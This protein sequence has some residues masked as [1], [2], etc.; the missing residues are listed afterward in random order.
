MTVTQGVMNRGMYAYWDNL[1]LLVLQLIQIRSE[2]SSLRVRDREY[3]AL[4][5]NQPISPDSYL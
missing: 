3:R 5:I 4:Y 1:N 2:F